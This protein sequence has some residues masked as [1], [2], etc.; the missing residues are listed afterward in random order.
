MANIKS[1]GCLVLLLCLSASSS[2]QVQSFVGKWQTRKWPPSNKS[3]ITVNIVKV[4]GRLSGTVLFVGPGPKEHEQALLN[5]MVSEN[6][7]KFQTAGSAGG[8]FEWSLTLNRNC[9]SGVLK[10]RSGK[11]GGEMYIEERVVKQE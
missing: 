8:F 5:P 6:T 10:G 7:L 11:S 1:L 4:H 2:A 9:R 3:A